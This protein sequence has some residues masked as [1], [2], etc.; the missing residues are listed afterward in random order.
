MNPQAVR[1]ETGMRLKE[2]GFDVPTDYG[3]DSKGGYYQDETFKVNY[4]GDPYTDLV[5][6]APTIAEVVMWLYEKHGIWVSVD[7]GMTGFYGHY[8]VNPQNTSPSNL[9]QGWANDQ[10]NPAKSITEAYESAIIYSLE[11]LI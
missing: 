8:K 7:I 2:K 10:D 9:K 1:F 11:K 6:S 5:C 4:N 3:Y